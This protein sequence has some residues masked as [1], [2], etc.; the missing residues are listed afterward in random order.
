MGRTA[1]IMVSLVASSANSPISNPVFVQAGKT[2]AIAYK[3]LEHRD[4]AVA[5]HTH[6]KSVFGVRKLVCALSLRL[7]S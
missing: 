6:S 1:Q 2:K 7:S 5:S 3:R 4:K